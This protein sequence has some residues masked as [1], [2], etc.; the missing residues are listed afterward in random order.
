MRLLDKVLQL[1]SRWS[2]LKM[3]FRPKPVAD[4]QDVI[5]R[6]NLVAGV[7][8]HP[9]YQEIEHEHDALLAELYQKFL[10]ADV[11]SYEQYI[12]L[13]GF[14]RGFA[15]HTN[16]PAE[17]ISEACKAEK[18]YRNKKAGGDKLTPTA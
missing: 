17:I 4:L 3:R 6:G 15:A 12:E 16:I 1:P 8:S 11:T 14:V 18:N 5:T 13:R 7:V 9:G 10:S 2:A